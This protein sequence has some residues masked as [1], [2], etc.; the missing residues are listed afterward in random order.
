MQLK[1][2][3]EK[4]AAKLLED[5]EVEVARLKEEAAVKAARCQE[6][7][8]LLMEGHFKATRQMLKEEL[9]I[10]EEEA[11]ERREE[12]LESVHAQ[13]ESHVEEAKRRAGAEFKAALEHASELR[14]QASDEFKASLQSAAAEAEKLKDEAQA[15]IGSSLAQALELEEQS[16]MA[17]ERLQGE[18]AQ[19]GELR[20]TAEQDAESIIREAQMTARSLREAAKVEAVTE[21]AR[22][23]SGGGSQ[24][25]LSDVRRG[26]RP[27]GKG[28]G[29]CAG[30]STGDAAGGLR[31]SRPVEEAEAGVELHA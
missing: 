23:A 13:A 5:A 18:V 4:E 17:R 10:I 7:K 26:L 21:V 3:A 29:E 22:R 14:R 16:V 15:E 28:G 2:K 9:R 12:E 25:N 6:E 8:R 27:V 31:A 11:R 24:S 20:R 19:L 30:P 1:W